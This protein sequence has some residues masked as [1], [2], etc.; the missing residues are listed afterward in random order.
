MIVVEID[1][2]VHSGIRQSSWEAQK[3]RRTTPTPGD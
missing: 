1:E 2:F 3:E